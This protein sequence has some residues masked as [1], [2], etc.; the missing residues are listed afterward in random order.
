MVK[1]FVPQPGA[2]AETRRRIRAK[3]MGGQEHGLI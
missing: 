2:D 3:N 1:A